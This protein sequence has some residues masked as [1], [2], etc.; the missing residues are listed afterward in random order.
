[1]TTGG[2][3]EAIKGL[4]RV[5]LDT[6]RIAKVSNENLLNVSGGNS[7]AYVY[8]SSP[9]EGE[10]SL[11][12]NIHNGGHYPLTG[13]NVTIRRVVSGSVDPMDEH[14]SERQVVADGSPAIPVDSLAPNEGRT[15]PGKIGFVPIPNQNGIATYLIFVNAQNPGTEEVLLFRKSKSGLGWAYKFD[16]WK[17]VTGKIKRGMCTPRAPTYGSDM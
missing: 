3:K 12:L 14:A 9:Y 2:L 4:N 7:F 8:P 16:A 6:Q 13:V 1:M 11:T 10:T 15:I 17:I 5:L